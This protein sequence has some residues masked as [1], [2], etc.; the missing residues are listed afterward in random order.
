MSPPVSNAVYMRSVNVF[1]ERSSVNSAFLFELSSQYRD[2][3][4]CGKVIN[5]KLEF[6]FEPPCEVFTSPP[7][8]VE[9]IGFFVLCIKI[10]IGIIIYH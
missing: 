4:L 6:S 7:T 5:E 2:R 9:S 8:T 1:M 3:F 10:V